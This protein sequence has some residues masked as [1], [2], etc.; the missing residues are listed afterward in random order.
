MPTMNGIEAARRIKEELP[1]TRVLI[2][3]MYDDEE[4]FFPALRVGASGYVLK[5]SEPQELLFAIRAVGSGHVFFTPL[6]AKS[7]LESFISNKGGMEEEKYNKLSSR[8]KEVIGLIAAGYTNREIAQKLFLSIRTVEKHR[9][10][11]MRKLELG[12]H[13]EL[14]KYAVRTGLID[15]EL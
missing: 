6:M 7:L 1:D 12:K 15:P 13:E 4:F 2:L 8:E 3:T 5:E 9:Q 10:S 11:A 14:M